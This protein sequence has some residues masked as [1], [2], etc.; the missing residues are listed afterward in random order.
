MKTKVIK[1][2]VFLGAISFS[3]ADAQDWIG[4]GSPSAPLF[5]T[6]F[7]GI[8]LSSP[9]AYTLDV[10][11]DI[12]LSPTSSLR[13]G[14][15]FGLR[16][17]GTSD[18]ILGDNGNVGIG[19][20]SPSHKLD[21]DGAVNIPSNF[22][23]KIDGNN[24][25][26]YRGS[27]NILLGQNTGNG[28]I[29]GF[30]N[31][32]G[33]IFIG[34]AAGNSAAYSFNNVLIGHSAGS[35][36]NAILFGGANTF[37][38]NSSG[39]SNNSTRNTF[40]GYNSGY[41]NTGQENTFIGSDA[42]HS[43]A[44]PVNTMNYSVLLGTRA[45]TTTYSG[46]LITLLG[47]STKATTGVVNSTAI[48][49][50][51]EVTASNSLVLGN[52]VNVGIGLGNPSYKLHLVGGDAYFDNNVLVG[53]PTFGFAFRGR[54][55]VM[56]EIYGINGSSQTCAGGFNNS[57]DGGEVIGV[58]GYAY[59]SNNA[60]YGV[61]GVAYTNCYENS[62]GYGVWGQSLNAKYNYGVYGKMDA[63]S[64]NRCEEAV[65]FHAVHGEAV[66]TNGLSTY[67][68]GYFNGDFYYSG[69]WK[70]SDRKLKE[71]IQTIKS[72]IDKIKLLKPSFYNY[73]SEDPALKG[74][75]MPK[76]INYGFIAQE[77]EEVFPTFV[78]ETINPARFD[79][80]G[81]EISP[82]VKFK[83]VDYI[84]II[85]ILTAGIQE[86]QQLLESQQKDIL[87]LKQEIIRLSGG[88]NKEGNTNLDLY[89]SQL[90]QNEPNP[91]DATTKIKY[92]VDEKSTSAKLLVFDMN[93]KFILEKV[94]IKFGTG[95]LVIDAKELSA[96]M[97]YYSL[98][99]DSK[100]I[101][102]KRMIVSY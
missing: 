39:S 4:G 47:Y 66:N 79:S 21:V 13:I 36:I 51:A 83:V 65:S 30:M 16:Q 31:S 42:G 43:I 69:A 91:F 95:E 88:T 7:V 101:D 37:I 23:Y 6:G 40:V 80:T 29:T 17:T 3:S 28:L 34:D 10:D 71:N 77:L 1:L 85:P 48:G 38:G 96:G 22:S 5:R 90:F 45:G 94:I 82:E 92:Q 73:K 15:L 2:M 8:G 76:G 33:N 60:N 74:L 70:S 50:N 64:S 75:H 57:G 55:T 14:S 98:I 63:E 93:G 56:H 44:Y 27:S 78:K 81:K 87:M 24:I 67:W 32:T 46:D 19:L 102:T 49:A 25:L 97:Y 41:D 89:E 68:A 59:G 20:T 62:E 84:S 12:N 18:F 54:T 35:S 52:N 26:T 99:V 11:G 86:Q 53:T 100:E 61:K 9:P 58:G 72:S